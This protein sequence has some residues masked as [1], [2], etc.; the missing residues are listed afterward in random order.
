MAK[1]NKDALEQV[2]SEI[3]R[4]LQAHGWTAITILDRAN[5]YTYSLGFTQK[6]LPEL[7]VFGIDPETVRSVLGEIFREVQAGRPYRKGLYQAEGFPMPFHL[8]PV[9]DDKARVLLRIAH[10]MFPGFQALQLVVPDER[11]CFPW[12]Q[13]C[14]PA[15]I[16]AQPIQGQRPEGPEH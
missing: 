7:V 3:R 16:A 11:G 8:L 5:P 1:D 14:D 13:G 12:D 6:G 10:S 15:Y 2:R 9:P 4:K